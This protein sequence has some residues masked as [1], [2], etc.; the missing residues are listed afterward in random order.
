MFKRGMGATAEQNRMRKEMSEM[1]RKRV[2][3]EDLIRE[4]SSPMRMIRDSVPS[5]AM[6]VAG[7]L[8]AIAS[9]VLAGIPLATPSSGIAT[10][11]TGD[12]GAR[13][14]AAPSLAQ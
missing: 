8:A 11:S 12:F 4:R 10:A 5:K 14:L 2:S 13:R 1:S 3:R 7:V 6:L 9:V